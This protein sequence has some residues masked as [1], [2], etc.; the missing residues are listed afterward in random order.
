MHL[1]VAC[2]KIIGELGI[3]ELA[4]T[5]V[6]DTQNILVGKQA[7]DRL[8]VSLKVGRL[9]GIVGLS[10]HNDLVAHCNRVLCDF[11]HPLRAEAIV[12][13]VC[14]GN[15]VIV[16][17]SGILVVLAVVEVSKGLIIATFGHKSAGDDQIGVNGL[18]SVTDHH[19]EVHNIVAAVFANQQSIG[20]AGSVLIE[21]VVSINSVI[22]IKLSLVEGLP[23]QVLDILNVCA[24][25]FQ[26]SEVFLAPAIAQVVVTDVVQV[27][28]VDLII[29]CQL[30]NNFLH[31]C[32]VALIVSS[33][34]CIIPL[35][36]KVPVAC[37]RIIFLVVLIVE[38]DQPS[39]DTDTLCMGCV[40]GLLK[41]VLILTGQDV[42]ELSL[43]I[44]QHAAGALGQQIDVG[45]THCCTAVNDRLCA[46]LC[47]CLAPNPFA[48]D[49]ELFLR[50]IFLYFRL[51]SR[52]RHNEHG[53]QQRQANEQ[54]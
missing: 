52:N 41:D 53:K 18:G 38:S 24:H 27:D 43:Q 50:Y 39:M 6:A 40:N 29:G 37:F 42:G 11:L 7:T 1:H 19:T 13:G 44:A 10:T 31:E 9:H 14:H 46:K 8:D 15:D 48:N 54:R 25:G 32:T 23:D 2:A 28:A 30:G 49:F 45:H 16:Q 33:Q 21:D 20:I 4:V 5:E 35:T 17:L 36:D 47:N 12:A 51:G 3:A 22:D 26:I 34:E